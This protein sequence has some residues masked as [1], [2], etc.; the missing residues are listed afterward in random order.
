MALSLSPLTGIERPF[1]DDEIIVSKTDLS[2]RIT[3]VNDVF[4]RVSAFS[5]NELIG[6]AHS[7][8]RHPD[9]P[10]GVFQLL[11]DTIQEGRELFA[12]VVN[13][14]KNGDHYWVYAHITPTFDAAGKIAGYHSNRRTVDRKALP[15]IEALYRDMRAVE[16]RQAR[17]QDAVSA[18][19]DYLNQNLSRL[20]LSYDEYVWTR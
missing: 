19:V 9:M 6:A 3:Y 12:Y 11:W 1:T 13:R 8:I 4:V 18:S 5:R 10:R 14:A 7:I 2:G 20:N 16:A 15:E 17:K